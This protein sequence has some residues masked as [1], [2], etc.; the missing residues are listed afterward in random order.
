MA[1]RDNN[2]NR[3]AE[4]VNSNGSLIGAVIVIAFVV[5]LVVNVVSNL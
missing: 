2:E 1:G 3:F 5:C 4:F